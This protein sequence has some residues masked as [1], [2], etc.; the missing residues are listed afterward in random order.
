MRLGLIPLT[1]SNTRLIVVSRIR[2][3]NANQ[4]FHVSCTKVYD[5]FLYLEKMSNNFP[6]GLLSQFRHSSEERQL[7]LTPQKIDPRSLN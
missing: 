1:K 7:S 4:Q 2:Q 5:I 3:V 6:T